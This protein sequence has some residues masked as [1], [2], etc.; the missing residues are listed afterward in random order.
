MRLLSTGVCFAVLFL[1]SVFT[2]QAQSPSNSTTNPKSSGAS[3]SG[4]ATDPD[5][6]VVPGAQVTLLRAMAELEERETNAQGQFNFENLPA[7]DYEIIARS[8]GF[9]QLPSSITLQPDEKGVADLHLRLSAVQDRVIVSAGPGGEL[10]TQTGS[11]LSVVGRQE[12]EDRGAQAALDVLRGLP[13][14]EINQSGGRGT[15]TSAFI[16]GG[17]SD[18]NL[19]MIDGIPMNDFGGGFDLAP[20]PVE[21]VEQVEVIRGPQSAIYGSNAVAGTINIE[22]ISGDGPPH[23]SFLGEAGSLYTWRVASEGSGLTHG[24]S[25]GYGMSRIQTRGQVQN[26]GYRNQ[27]LTLNLGYSRSQRREFHAH[28]FGDAGAVGL[29]GPYGSDPDEFFPGI[30]PSTHQRQNLFGYQASYT[31]RF[32]SKFQQVSSVS[33]STDHLEFISPSEG[34]SFTNNLRLAASTRSE[35]AVSSKDTFVAGFEYDR[36][37]FKNT[38]VGD[39]TGV[40]F[41]LG[42]NS[43]AGFAENRWTP[44]DRWYITAGVRLDGIQTDSLPTIPVVPANTL[45]KVS[46]RIAAAFLLRNPT[47]DGFFGATRLHSSFGTGFRPPNGFE[48][49]FTDNPKLKPEESISVDAGIE[50]RMARD[51][52]IF[53]VTYFY[54][55]F[56]DQIVSTGDLPANFDSENIGRSRAYGVETSIRIRPIRSLEFSGSYTWTNT[57][58]L[59]LAGFPDTVVDPFTVGEPLLRRPHNAAGFNATWTKNRLMLNMSGTIRGAVLDIEPNEGTFACSLTNPATMLPYQCLF[60]NP[61]YELLNAGFAYQLPKGVEI[62]GHINNFLNQRYEEAFGFPSLRLNFIAGFKID[63]PSP[64]RR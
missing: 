57:A 52:A 20:L 46:P 59:A 63:L 26:D 37:S 24:F 50:Q 9:D 23:F 36:D 28:F 17:D 55:H 14:L 2:T 51:R 60:R 33:V 56:K 22:T 7:G 62:Y 61:G 31:E 53:D 32:S 64:G 1:S 42:R 27:Q 29:P 47:G 44:S 48:L 3:I 25:W 54:N 6:R 30:D 19:I 40:P 4:T 13:G 5:G 35:I 41:T 34:D 11:S 16:R 15:V 18:Y 21:G 49:A 38:F 43:Y 10:T 8:S 45:V 58:I 12:I 39:A